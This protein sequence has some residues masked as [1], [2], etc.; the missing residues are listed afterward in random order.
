MNI[1]EALNVEVPK[2]VSVSLLDETLT[3]QLLADM[4]ADTSNVV[5]AVTITVRPSLHGVDPKVLNKMLN[6][7]IKS[8]V[9]STRGNLYTETCYEFTQ[10]GVIHWHSLYV[11]RISNIARLLAALRRTFGFCM[12]KTPNQL[13]GWRNYMRKEKLCRPKIILTKKNDGAISR[14]PL[15][16]G[17]NSK[18]FF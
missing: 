6:N 15:P 11:G 12:V 7:I 18:S 4:C 10:A 3:E 17:Q 13:I 8:H 9:C 5:R 2:P 1:F 14:A 16:V